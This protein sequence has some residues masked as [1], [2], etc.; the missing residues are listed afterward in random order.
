MKN[1]K[2]VGLI[3]LT[4]TNFSFADSGTWKSYSS[5]KLLCGDADVHVESIC[6]PDK[7]NVD[8]WRV[9]GSA[10][11]FITRQN[12]TV[13]IT[14]PQIPQ[15]QQKK[16]EIQGY[17]FDGTMK[18]GRWSPFLLTCAK[19]HSSNPLLVMSYRLGDNDLTE[20]SLPDSL[21]GI[22]VVT[23]LEGKLIDGKTADAARHPVN[24]KDEDYPEI[25]VNGVY[26]A[27]SGN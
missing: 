19:T 20:E 13:K 21:A 26:I 15:K 17:K 22:P 5:E 8:E 11:M 7:N 6:Q 1:A 2:L 25:A 3:V 12:K 27:V 18:I 16:L 24:P 14:L 10:S 4:V 23:D 9:C